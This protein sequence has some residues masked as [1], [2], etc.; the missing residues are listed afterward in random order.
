MS[1]KFYLSKYDEQLKNDMTESYI[2]TIMK[3][4][5]QHLVFVRR[6]HKTSTIIT[7]FYGTIITIKLLNVEMFGTDVHIR[8]QY[9]KDNVMMQID[10]NMTNMKIDDCENILLTMCAM[11][12]VKSGQKRK[13]MHY[14]A[15]ERRHSF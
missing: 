13:K 10:D 15:N 8:M 1:S 11:Y 5:H 14:L 12:Y 9:M 6:I 2:S 3:K 7:Y 4:L